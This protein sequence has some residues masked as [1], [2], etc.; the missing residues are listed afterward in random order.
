MVPP[1]YQLRRVGH[2]TV[3]F[4]GR[5]TPSPPIPREDGQGTEEGP[6]QPLPLIFMAIRNT[7]E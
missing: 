3:S 7:F 2:D 6:I 5:S 4:E 1:S